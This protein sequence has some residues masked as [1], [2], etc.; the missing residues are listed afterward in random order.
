MQKNN[1][2]NHLFFSEEDLIDH[3]QLIN[4]VKFTPREV[5]II[6]C[7]LSG[8][9][10]Q[11]IANFLSSL[12]KSIEL[13]TVSTHI[14][15]IRR[16]IEGSARGS[17]IEFVEKSDK[18]QMIR[19]YYLNLLIQK[20]FNKSLQEILPLVKTNIEK[21]N[22]IAYKQDLDEINITSLI[23]RLQN[24]LKLLEINAY[25]ESEQYFSSISALPRSS[26]EKQYIIHVLPRLKRSEEQSNDM[27]KNL[28]QQQK[29]KEEK[30][31]YLQRINL[32]K[33]TTKYCSN[34]LLLV[35]DLENY[36]NDLA[37][38][39]SWEYV[40]LS[41]Y[42]NQNYYVLFFE[43]LKKLLPSVATNLEE[44]SIKFKQRYESIYGREIIVAPEPD[45]K[46]TNKILSV[47]K[48]FLGIKIWN[49]FISLVSKRPYIA[50]YFAFL[51]IA[52]GFLIDWYVTS[53]DHKAGSQYKIIEE[54]INQFAEEL[55]TDQ[56]STQRAKDNHSDILSVQEAVDNLYNKYN[57]YLSQADLQS[58][59]NYLSCALAG[60]YRYNRDHNDI[61]V[62]NYLKSQHILS[63]WWNNF[64]LGEF[65]DY[66]AS[67]ILNRA[68]NYYNIRYGLTDTDT[69]EVIKDKLARHTYALEDYILLNYYLSRG[70]M[71]SLMKDKKN[72]EEIKKV[73]RYLD[74]AILGK[75]YNMYEA[76]AAEK[77]KL[78][79]ERDK[80]Q[81]SIMELKQKLKEAFP[82][83]QNDASL[84]SIINQIKSK[85][86]NKSKF[87]K[88]MENFLIAYGD[89]ELKLQ[90]I[91]GGFLKLE[92]DDHK[93]INHYKPWRKSQEEFLIP[94]DAFFNIA[95]MCKENLRTQVVLMN[96]NILAHYD[97][98][99]KLQEMQMECLSNSL[100]TL[101]RF[102]GHSEIQNKWGDTA[103]KEQKKMIAKAVKQL[104]SAYYDTNIAKQLQ[105]V[106]DKIQGDKFDSDVGHDINIIIQSIS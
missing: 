90:K 37:N 96:Y 13:Q 80:I 75:E 17:I 102:L 100:K 93:Y 92:S 48:G 59:F 105:A 83:V 72:D 53:S 21:V 36:K 24:H 56:T 30:E 79:I 31:S 78:I 98:S 65:H 38:E 67:N 60:H 23:T 10:P 106:A 5:D 95:V 91:I 27:Q 101:S 89:K 8:K 85:E 70:Y 71:S 54:K 57:K 2:Q 103:I 87:Q 35:Q 33:A 58:K 3:L 63:L 46:Q 9:N 81:I 34:N 49:I 74:I 76:C 14:A 52:S 50:I 99:Q 45:S 86:Q 41:I 51:V 15:N 42:S 66:I 29:H 39:Q 61:P 88:T 94:K 26:Q 11:A 20:E 62:D 4:G 16:K 40:D 73:E 32:P 19:N 77:N 68:I 22:I 82:V 104:G 69:I 18:H 55:T 43:I 44:V 97:N 1:I 7:I 6:S 47:K 25:R 84:V 64:N 12:S 28:V